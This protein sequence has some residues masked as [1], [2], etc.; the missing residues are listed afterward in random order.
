MGPKGFG[1]AQ[2]VADGVVLATEPVTPIDGRW[3]IRAL[4]V[5]GVI[6]QP[7]ED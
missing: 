1:V 2:E 4:L 3:P 6:L 5:T 7:G